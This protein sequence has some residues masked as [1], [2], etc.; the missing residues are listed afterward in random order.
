MNEEK[1]R[2]LFLLSEIECTRFYRLC[3]EYWPDVDEYAKLRKDSPWW[4]VET[5]FGLIKIGWRKRVIS[6]D[7]EAIK[8]RGIITEDDVTKTDTMVHA[9][10]YVKAIEYLINLRLESE[11]CL[12]DAIMKQALS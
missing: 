4:L 6:I 2:A 8:F 9:W 3:N 7:W 1:C 10:S 5:P 12:T 11:K